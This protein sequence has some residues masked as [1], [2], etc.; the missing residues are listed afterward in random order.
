MGVINIG[1]EGDFAHL[2]AFLKHRGLSG[3]KIIGKEAG[4][5]PTSGIG[6]SSIA[7]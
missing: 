6:K 1:I 7:L 3:Y 5:I 2:E 4:I